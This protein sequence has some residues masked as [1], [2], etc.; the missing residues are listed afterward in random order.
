MNKVKISG[1]I[2]VYEHSRNR[3]AT[4][5][6]PYLDCFLQVTEPLIIFIL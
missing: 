5:E 3:T 4:F 6:N 2:S 1:V